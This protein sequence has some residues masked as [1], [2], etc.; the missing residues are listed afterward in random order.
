MKEKYIELMEKALSAYTDEHIQSYFNEVKENG[1][2]EHG[3]PR[4]TSNIGILIAHGRRHDLLPIFREMMEFCCKTIPTVKAANDFSVR[5]IVCCLLEIEKNKIVPREDTERWR[6]YLATI[7]PVKC[8][9]KFA[10]A[11]TDNVRNWALFT[12][13][14]EYFRLDAGIGGS[15]DFIELQ[16]EQ[17]LQWFDEMSMYRDYAKADIHQPMVYDLVARGL[18]TLLL[19]RGYRGRFYGQIDD[20]LKKAALLMLDTQSPNGELPFGGR[21]NQFLHNE[22]WMVTV[23]EYEA[24]RYKREGNVALT[25]AFSAASA[26]ALAVTEHWLSKNPIRHIKNRFPTETKYGCEAYA[27]FDKYMITAASFLYTAYLTCDD[28]IAYE[29][30]PD[31]ESKI[32][33]TS[34]HFHKLFLKSGGYGLEFDFDADPIQDANGLG[35]IHR[36]GAPSTI[37]LSCPC[38]EKPVYTVDLEKP[39]AFSMCSAIREKDGWYMGAKEGTA[40]EVLESGTNR[41]NASATI[42]CKFPNDRTVKEHYAVNEHGVSIRIEGDGAIGFALPAFCFDGEAFPEIIAEENSLTVAYEGWVC[43]YTTS[44]TISDLHQVAANRNGHYRVFLATDQ[45][46]LNVKIE[47]IRP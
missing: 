32:A 44:G 14:S 22:P 9:N 45:N 42:L 35:R 23:F 4:L 39:F 20:H 41:E 26:R 28:S 10:K 29:E 3:F 34:K 21:S 8:Y 7:D 38:P 1:L 18:F 37:C 31:S 2:T 12:A 16:I 19:D 47:I 24:K 6:G 27:Y 15:I 17:Q 43:R 25:A 13:V 11:T 36:A 33:V 46:T 40:Y 30:I 5:E